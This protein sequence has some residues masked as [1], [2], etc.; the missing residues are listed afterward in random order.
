MRKALF[1]CLQGRNRSRTGAELFKTWPN[2]ETRSAGSDKDAT[3]PIKDEDIEW[4]SIIFTMEK[5]QEKHLKNRYKDMIKGKRIICLH[6]PDNYEFGDN[7]L[8][9]LL[10]IKAARYFTIN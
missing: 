1:I 5:P 3:F 2:C 6:I 7:E 8:K 10:E 4:A 9:D